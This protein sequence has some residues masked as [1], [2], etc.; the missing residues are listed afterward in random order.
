M[1][2]YMHTTGTRIMAGIMPICIHV[3]CIQNVQLN[4]CELHVQCILHVYGLFFS[5]PPLKK[6]Q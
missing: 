6:K 4:N 1:Y 5:K 3:Q 2:M